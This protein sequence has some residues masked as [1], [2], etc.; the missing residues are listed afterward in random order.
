[1]PAE[2]TLGI[3]LKLLADFQAASREAVQ[4]LNG[5]SKGLAE[6]K[7]A[8]ARADVTGISELRSA[9]DNLSSRVDAVVGKMEN[10]VGATSRAGRASK[11]ATA[12]VSEFTAAVENVAKGTDLA[13]RATAVLARSLGSL[14]SG[15]FAAERVGSSLALVSREADGASRAVSTLQQ[16]ILSLPSSRTIHVRVVTDEGPRALSGNRVNETMRNVTPSHMAMLGN[17]GGGAPNEPN[18]NN[19]AWNAGQ[20]SRV[21]GDE[22]SGPPIGVPPGGFGGGHGESG[23][24]L[25][26]RMRDAGKKMVSSSFDTLIAGAMIVGPMMGAIKYATD[27]DDLM[28]RTLEALKSAGG[29]DV[30]AKAFNDGIRKNAVNFGGDF[31]EIV[32]SGYNFVSAL[33]SAAHVDWNDESQRKAMIE[34]HAMIQKMVIAGSSSTHKVSMEEGTLDVLATATNLGLPMANALQLAKSLTAAANIL[35]LGKNRTSSEIDKLANSYKA[36]GPIASLGGVSTEELVGLVNLEAE[37]KIR[38]ATAGQGI[39][40]LLTRAALPTSKYQATVDSIKAQ[41]GQSVSMFNED[42]SRANLFDFLANIDKVL[43][44]GN[45]GKPLSAKTTAGVMST[46]AGLYANANLSEMV[47]E[48]GLLGG[49]KGLKQYGHDAVH[50]NISGALPGESATDTSYRLRKDIKVEASTTV[51]NAA[52]EWQK[53]FVLIEPDLIKLLHGINGLIDAFG[54]LPDPV[55]KF[56]VEAVI[57]GGVLLTAAAGIGLF[58][59]GLL[60]FGS[61]VAFAVEKIGELEILQSIGGLFTSIG[62]IAARTAAIFFGPLATAFRFAVAALIP[63]VGAVAGPIVVIGALV[64]A[65]VLAYTAWKNNWFGIQDITHK[66][67]AYVSGLLP[68]IANSVAYMLGQVVGRLSEALPAIQSFLGSIGTKISDGLKA[69]LATVSSFFGFFRDHGLQIATDFGVG[70]LTGFPK[71]FAAAGRAL[72]DGFKYLAGVRDNAKASYELGKIDAGITTNFNHE[73]EMN[74]SRGSH[75]G[76]AVDSDKFTDSTPGALP[77]HSLAAFIPKR[78]RLGGNDSNDVSTEIGAGNHGAPASLP[79]SSTSLPQ[80][81][82]SSS[83]ANYSYVPPV[84]NSASNST[85]SSATDRAIQDAFSGVKAKKAK[86]A[87]KPKGVPGDV[88]MELSAGE[89]VKQIESDAQKIQAALKAAGAVVKEHWIDLYTGGK[90]TRVYGDPKAYEIAKIED[91]AKRA[92]KDN[93][94][95]DAWNIKTPFLDKTIDATAEN[96]AKT[97]A[98]LDGILK[99]HYKTLTSHQIAEIRNY[100]SEVR[101][102]FNSSQTKIQNQE[103]RDLKF[104]ITAIGKTD[105]AFSGFDTASR[106][107][108]D[109]ANNDDARSSRAEGNR[110]DKE[111]PT[112]RELNAELSIEIAERRTLSKDME[113]ESDRRKAIVVAMEGIISAK[114]KLNPK[115]KEENQSISDLNDKYDYY[116]HSLEN[117]DATMDGAREKISNLTKTI[118]EHNVA[119]TR[120]SS[121]S[122]AWS[123]L[124]GASF[125]D[126]SKAAVD[127]MGKDFSTSIDGFIERVLG[128]KGKSGSP[129]QKAIGTF[130]GTFAKS[131]FDGLAKS[132]LEPFQKS[133]EESLGGGKSIF[134]KGGAPGSKT[135]EKAAQVTTD[136]T[137]ALKAAPISIDAT[138]KANVGPSGAHAKVLSTHIAPGGHHDK[139]LQKH[140]GPGGTHDQVL[141]AAFASA[142]LNSSSL[143]SSKNSSFAA[144]TLG[145]DILGSNGVADM[146]NASFG[147]DAWGASVSPGSQD[148]ASQAS[149]LQSAF[150]KASGI[151]GGGIAAYEGFKQGGIGG[152]IEAFGGITALLKTIAPHFGPIGIGVAAVAGLAAM[153]IHH[154]DPA[155]MP[156]KYDA[157]RFTDIQAE[158]LGNNSHASGYARPTDLALD[159]VLKS[160]GGV[161]QL[162]FIQD[163]I[164]AG[165]AGLTPQQ[166]ADMKSA[167]GTSGGGLTYDKNIGQEKV[168]GGSLNGSYTDIAAAA[169]AATDA[170]LAVKGATLKTA[171]DAAAM[172]ASFTSLILGGPAGFSGI[173]YAATG[174]GSALA[175]GSLLNFGGGSR[176]LPTD[177]RGPIGGA[178]RA[179]GPIVIK[180]LE[181]AHLV[182]GDPNS[183][184]TVIAASMPNIVNE[185]RRVNYQES[186]LY[187]NYASATS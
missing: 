75:Y 93:P 70:L 99:S 141:R 3:R 121:G 23:P 49:S 157:R 142:G 50:G 77:Q 84:A 159:P 130:I 151:V 20:R 160:T 140:L 71:Q 67:V 82:G 21:G 36:I 165:G 26:G 120:A 137:V 74:S 187:G 18:Y 153:L 143:A 88:F 167:F 58:V 104:G 114:S 66:A 102:F 154:D 119:I 5:I 156:D 109:H 16:R 117:V 54:R 64:A 87:K 150:G 168:V 169:S 115:N 106:N 2:R 173:P 158:L 164:K 183:I 161:G 127:G 101:N 94:V 6:V 78:L 17:G 138:L 76:T 32:S 61:Q 42:G 65:T 146:Q 126:A 174:G 30:S 48:A 175:T 105:K 4:N 152:G 81:S 38:G 27:I 179:T 90:I 129:F 89:T 118:N 10:F 52:S 7:K 132:M 34:S 24:P 180:I 59:G 56:G 1:M 97:L 98:G 62:G 37:G 79:G 111:V 178:P 122:D 44:T 19:R 45:H 149:W 12:D 125:K 136:N 144:K 184:A 134:G 107:F 83:P 28:H 68:Q 113:I 186:Q 41:T 155:K 171:Q 116:V 100:E 13:V 47:H 176:R 73:K 25:S 15:G 170:I 139:I 163:Y 51:N 166:M 60:M 128:A 55:K 53:T 35:I 110:K 11:K 85:A 57:F 123:K 40:R 162:K 145:L 31:R 46:L 182:G 108:N 96:E 8:G 135:A 39:K 72:Q 185:I 63:I 33:P 92:K 181:G 131:I 9:I 112:L 95:H 147:S 86:K 124:V 172:A 91:K 103:A 43:K 148:E 133:L 22:G 80:V 29:T 14:S 177:S 69:C